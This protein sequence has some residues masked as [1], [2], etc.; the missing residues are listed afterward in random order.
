MQK[1]S[2]SLPACVQP[3]GSG[4]CQRWVQ[5]DLFNNL[6]RLP[7][8]LLRRHVAHT[9]THTLARSNTERCGAASMV[10]MECKGLGNSLAPGGISSLP[11]EMGMAS[12]G[13]SRISAGRHVALERPCLHS[14]TYSLDIR[15]HTHA[16]YTYKYS[17]AHRLYPCISS[18]VIARLVLVCMWTSRQKHLLMRLFGR[19]TDCSCNWTGHAHHVCNDSSANG[20]RKIWFVS[21]AIVPVPNLLHKVSICSEMPSGMCRIRKLNLN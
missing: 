4:A 8:L 10:M 21:S 5:T 6:S 9:H 2:R 16:L 3:S 18:W 13:P 19:L 15:A 7:Q 20:F 12:V 1:W 11:N 17:N 14:T